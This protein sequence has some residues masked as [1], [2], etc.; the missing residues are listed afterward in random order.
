MVGT[1]QGLPSWIS[2]AAA[3]RVEIDGNLTS[4]SGTM[5]RE[6]SEES[7]SHQSQHRSSDLNL[8]FG[9]R[10]FSAAGAAVL[11]AI[12]VNP[13]DVAKTRLQAQAAGVAYDDLCSMAC[14]ET[15]TVGLQRLLLDFLI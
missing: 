1:K 8:G 9:E 6:G 7:S 4:V 5:V 15:N 11:S 3:S 2:A 14:F 10:A 12:L 13:L